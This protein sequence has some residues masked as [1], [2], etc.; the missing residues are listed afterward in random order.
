VDLTFDRSHC[1]VVAEDWRL[2]EV[3]P[4][5]ED[6]DDYESNAGYAEYVPGQQVPASPPLRSSPGAESASSYDHGADSQR[7]DLDGHQGYLETPIDTQ[8]QAPWP[9]QSTGYYYHPQYQPANF[10]QRDQSMSPPQS[11]AP[12]DSSQSP[13]SAGPIQPFDFDLSPLNIGNRTPV[14]P[15]QTDTPA[16]PGGVRQVSWEQTSWGQFSAQ[17]SLR[18]SSA[19]GLIGGTGSG[20]SSPSPARGS[21]VIA[22]QYSPY[23]QSPML[24]P[25]NRSNFLPKSF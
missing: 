9:Q 5:D 24:E 15:G 7:L 23:T 19:P 2:V 22:P 8:H 3:G 10:H 13:I 20:T 4:N 17:A 14:P 25:V 1:W 6:F 11:Y 21:P 12:R 18:K 16:I